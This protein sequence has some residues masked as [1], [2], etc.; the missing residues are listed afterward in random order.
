MRRSSTSSRLVAATV[1]QQ[2]DDG[3][4]QCSVRESR[5]GGP[6]RVD[7][8]AGR[9]SGGLG[10]SNVPQPHRAPIGCLGGLRRFPVAARAA[11]C[12][13]E[14]PSWLRHRIL[15]PTCEGSSPSSPA[16]TSSSCSTHPVLFNTVLRSEEHTSEL[17]SQSNLVCRL[18][19]EKKN[20]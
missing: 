14:S 8:V 20:K 18:M 10:R 3:V 11:T 15:I 2:P 4:G 13:G 19:L 5:R 6:T 9:N 16:K 7:M 17:Q 12:V 1:R